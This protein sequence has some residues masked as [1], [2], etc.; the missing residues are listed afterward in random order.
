MATTM[1]QPVQVNAGAWRVSWSSD[2]TSP[3]Y[4]IWFQGRV[5][6]RQYEA[7]CMIEAT[8]EPHVEIDDESSPAIDQKTYPGRAVLQWFGVSGADY[9]KVEQNTGSWVE[10]DRR[11]HED[12]TGYFWYESD[13]LND[14]TTHSFR[15][16]AIDTAGN[17][18]T[19]VTFSMTIARNPSPPTPTLTYAA[20]TGLLQSA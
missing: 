7:F 4:A 1:N 9:Y 2:Q 6:S 10:V 16:S 18:G 8:G 12:G 15:V 20:G 17:A 11:Y 14:I 19:A 5:I 13:W 3:L